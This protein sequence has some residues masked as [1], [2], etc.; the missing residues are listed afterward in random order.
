[1]TTPWKPKVEWRDPAALI[2]YVRNAKVHSQEQIQ[3]VAAAISEFGFTQPIVI[4]KEGVIIAGHCRREAAIQLLM[5]EVPVVEASHLT[6]DQVI[7][8]R[9]ADN[10]V[11]EAPWDLELLRFDI[12]ALNSRDFNLQLT[13]F[14]MPQIE[15]FLSEGELSLE[16]FNNNEEPPV[17]VKPKQEIKEPINEAALIKRF[18]GAQLIRGDSAIELKKLESDS[19][20]SLV[21]DPPAGIAFMG[22]EWDEDKGGS[23]QWIAWLEGIMRECLRVMRPGA[24]GLVWALPRTSHWTATALEQAGFEIRDV[25]TH[26]FGSGFPKSLDVSKAIDKAAGAEREVIGI[27]PSSRPNSKKAGMRGFDNRDEAPEESAGV[28]SI[29]APT[30]EAAKQWDGWGT[31][32]KPASEHWIL[33]RKP[34]SDKTVAANVLKHGTGGINVDASRI[35]GGPRQSME[36]SVTNK[37][38]FPANFILSHN[39]DCA[40]ECTEGC[41][42]A[43]LDEQSGNLKSGDLKANQYIDGKKGQIY[44]KYGG[45]ET[46]AR[47]GDSGGA[48]RFFYCAKPSASEKND[49]LDEMSAKETHRYG[50]G[51]GGSETSRMDGAM[52]KNFHPTVKSIK[53]MTYLIRMITPERGT[54]LD[55]FMGS[56]TT[57]VAARESEFGFIGIEQSPEYFEIAEKRISSK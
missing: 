56:G 14:E 53:L 47:K 54:V 26:V 29:T 2:P 43:A 23:T 11:S 24:H 12:G 34:L 3:K 41:V 39:D 6:E 37:G 52:D 42:V 1:M 7:A 15:E 25:V 57:G 10:R 38:R 16:K 27:N 49:G 35:E 4:D 13:G 9:I 55:C 33:I 18:D 45:F 32:L 40:D 28:Q 17:P 50:A 36:Q 20:D 46:D 8:A 31:A 48:S 44:G 21:T 22:K 5:K 30:T 19:V 51:L